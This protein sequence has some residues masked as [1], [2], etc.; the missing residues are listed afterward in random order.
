MTLQALIFD[1]DGTLA[2][3]ASLA[4]ERGRFDAAVD[5]REH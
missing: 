1:V 4:I 5:V 3:T 2:E